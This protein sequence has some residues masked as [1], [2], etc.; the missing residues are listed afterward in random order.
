MDGKKI[1][2]AGCMKSVGFDYQLSMGIYGNDS[3]GGRFLLEM[4]EKPV[5]KANGCRNNEWDSI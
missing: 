2:L 3:C 5:G 4:L 1:P